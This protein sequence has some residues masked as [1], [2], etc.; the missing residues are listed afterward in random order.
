[1]TLMLESVLAPI[2]QTYWL[3][4]IGLIVAVIAYY[5]ILYILSKPRL[6]VADP[7]LIKQILVKDFNIFRNRSTAP[8]GDSQAMSKARDED[9]KRV[10]DIASPTFTSGKMRK[11]YALIN[12][13]GQEFIDSLD[14]DVS[15]GMNEIELKRVIS[16]Y[17]MDVIASCAFST[18]INTYADPNNPFTTK[19]ANISNAPNWKRLLQLTLPTFIVSSNIYR[20]HLSTGGSDAAFFMDF[21]RSLMKKRRDNKEKHNDFLQL[22]MNSERSDGDI[23]GASDAN[24]AHHVNEGKDEITADA[25]AF[26]GVLEKKLT[27]EQILNKCFSFFMAGY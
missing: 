9:W 12:H 26:T 7:Q 8:G 4:L 14:K 17:T 15:N 16:A 6:T 5:Y 24:E 27:E 25:E 23:R 3:C 13:C 19:V 10:R 18:K 2:F 20:K 21:S 22:L 1:M 11:M